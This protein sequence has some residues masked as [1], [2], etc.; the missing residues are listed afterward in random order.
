FVLGGLPVALVLAAYNW[1][2][3]GSPTSLGYQYTTL[4]ADQNAQGIVS[5][6]VPSVGVLADLLFNPRGLLVLAPWLALAPLGLLAARDRAIRAEVLVS[7]AVCAVF[8]TYNSGAL[9]PFGGWTPGPRYLVPML[10]FAA[11]LVALAPRRIRPITG[12]LMAWSVAVMLLATATRPNAQ[13]LYANPLVEL[14]IPRLLA[15][16][17][18]D[19]LAWHRWG[20]TGIEPLLLLAFGVVIAVAG[21]LATRARDR[22]SNVVALASG[23]ALGVLIVA[24]AVPAPAPAT[25]LM[26]GASSA[27]GPPALGVAASGAYRVT[28][29]GEDHM[30]M[31]AQLANAGGAVDGTRIEYRVAPADDLEAAK[32]V[33]YGDVA[34]SPGERDASSLAWTVDPGVDP[35]TRAWQVR[36]VGPDE[37]VLATT[38]A[39]RPFGP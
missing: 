32:A 13:E 2:T 11:V 12:V 25:V 20:F 24:C 17:L 10:P 36:V 38:G 26:P 27:D 3:F 8:L 37:E 35:A 28:A 23:I 5:I 14:W 15:G 30:V 9:N 19:S 39:F 31:W 33:W 7:A 16:H 29:G 1:V 6:V 18:A 22:A 21:L 34:W 4:F